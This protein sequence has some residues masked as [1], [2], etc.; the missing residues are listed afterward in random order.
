[1][2]RYLFRLIM[3]AVVTAVLCPPASG[4]EQGGEQVLRTVYVPV[5]SHV[6][7]APRSRALNL[8]TTLMVRNTDPNESIQVLSIRYY[9]SQGSMLKEFFPQPVK[10]SPLA[11]THVIVEQEDESGGPGP[12][13][14]VKW[15]GK[16]PVNP[17]M[18]QGIMIT[19]KSGLGVSFVTQGVEI[20]DRSH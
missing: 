18:V 20:Q 4:A 16:T 6:Y 12:S 9:D 11:S 10:L 8:T 13:F 1:M 5:Y 15:S 3:L 7:G 2:E 19:T 17:P 14:L